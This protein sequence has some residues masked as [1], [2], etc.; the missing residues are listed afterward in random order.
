MQQTPAAAHE[1]R[2]PAQF[3]LLSFFS[4]PLSRASH[5]FSSAYVRPRRFPEHPHETSLFV[6]QP[7]HTPHRRPK[8]MRRSGKK[9]IL[10]SAAL[11]AV[12]GTSCG[13]QGPFIPGRA[14]A[15]RLKQA[16]GRP[17]V[18]PPCSAPP[19]GGPS[20][21]LDERLL[22]DGLVPAIFGGKSACLCSKLGS[23]A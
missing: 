17:A 4:R 16:A 5:V 9:V 18:S 12:L 22:R 15:I 10:V 11:L 7:S 1:P 19:G 6:L 14:G 3:K 13:F 8:Q 2:A 23:A 20:M 21:A